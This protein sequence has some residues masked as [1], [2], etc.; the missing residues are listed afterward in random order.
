[1]SELEGLRLVVKQRLDAA[2]EEI[3]GLFE[4]TR[5]DYEEQLSRF[6][7]AEQ[8]HKLLDDV[9]NPKVQLHR[10][11][12][13]QLLVIKGDFLPEWSPG[14]DHEDTDPLHIK[15]EQEKVWIGPEGEHL[16][17]L[18]EA[19][20]ARFS[21]TP[22]P[23][24]IKDEDRSSQLH[25]SPTQDN[26]EAEPPAGCSATQIK[27][28]T[29]GEDRG[30]SEPAWNPEPDTE[31]QPN[32]D[33]ERASDSSDTELSYDDWQKPLS[34]SGSETEDSDDDWQKSLSDSGSETEDSD[35]ME[36]RAPEPAANALKS[37]EVPL[38]DEGCNAGKKSLGF[39][40]CSRRFY[41]KEWLQS[42]M[43][44]HF[45]KRS[46]RYL[47]REKCLRANQKVD[48]QTRVHAGEKLSG[49]DVCGKVL[50]RKTDLQRHMRIHTGEK[51]FGCD[52]CGKRFNRRSSLNRHIRIHTG[53]KPFGCDVCGKR[54]N[55]Q[56]NR[57]IHMR[58]HT[59]E[60][61]F[62][63]DVCGKGCNQ[64]AHLKSHMGI[65]T[66][67]KPFVCDICGKKFTWKANFKS[68]MRAHTG[69]K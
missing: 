40:K 24:K 46:S 39:F 37:K 69:E 61:P 2:A 1:M 17:G 18:E 4:K 45:G 57:K 54:F 50:N 13:Q 22:V 52:V 21:F 27:T 14:L 11:D 66:G 56:S 19:D 41:Y 8:R 23:V 25:Q 31:S 32:T 28:E 49:C 16:N 60:K 34:D 38:S 30:G 10:S 67:E 58:I 43:T 63:C 47:V 64:L 29:D 33:D 44:C 20:I 51:P 7:E 36:T 62:V 12:V 26:R 9:F 42:H 59:G 53:E 35:W 55:Q 3:F 15:E 6:K 5:A 68:H 48:S 65:H